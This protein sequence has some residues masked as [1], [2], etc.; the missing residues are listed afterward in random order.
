MILDT[1]TP[2]AVAHQIV[3]PRESPLEIQLPT[4]E[5]SVAHPSTVERSTGY[6]IDSS[7]E[8]QLPTRTTKQIQQTGNFDIRLN[9]NNWRRRTQTQQRLGTKGW[10]FFQFVYFEILKSYWLA[11]RF[12]II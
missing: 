9:P 3:N 11:V 6:P 8:N 1:K 4:V 12:Q 10:Y 5:R 7:N 2:V